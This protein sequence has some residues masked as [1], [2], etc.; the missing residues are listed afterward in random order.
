MEKEIVKLTL[1]FEEDLYLFSDA[2]KSQIKP[3]AE[4]Q[5]DPIFENNFNVEIGI[6]NGEFITHY[7]S[8]RKN[9]NFL[10][11]EIYRKI[12]RKAR[13]RVQKNNLK[14]V[15]L[16]Q[17]DASFF[18]PLLQD[19]SV[20]NFYI[21]FPDPWP[22]KKHNKRRLLKDQFL[23]IIAKKLVKG[24]KL[25]IATDHVDYAQDIL[26]NLKVVFE[27]KPQFENYFINELIDYYPTKYYRK[28]AIKS[29]VHFFVMERI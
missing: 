28:F 16:I 23:K 21:N 25:F 13:A 29:Q 17:Y 10:G 9:E 6:G 1:N 7:A 3:L 20:L 12:F 8:E 27:L 5:L 14:N 15:R 11:F 24:G 26:R 19:N 18:V 2:I 4:Y 22:K